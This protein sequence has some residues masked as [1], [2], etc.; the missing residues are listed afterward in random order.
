MIVHHNGTRIKKVPQ[1]CWA[2]WISVEVTGRGNGGGIVLYEVGDAAKEGRRRAPLLRDQIWRRCGLLHLVRNLI[3]VWNEAEESHL[4]IRVVHK[5]VQL[6]WGNKYCMA[7]LDF[8]AFTLKEQFALALDDVND[9]LVIVL[10]SQ[11]VS[12]GG[13][14]EH[15]HTEVGCAVVARDQHPNA[16]VLDSIEFYRRCCDV[17]VTGILHCDSG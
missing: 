16:D 14:L 4:L 11:G 7:S 12:S 2:I 10:V 3:A 8:A 17:F 6:V 1:I 9:M 13:K 5:L 15:S